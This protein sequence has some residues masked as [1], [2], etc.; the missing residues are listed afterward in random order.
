MIAFVFVG[1]LI[2]PTPPPTF[3]RNPS[4]MFDVA[5]VVVL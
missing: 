3:L 2:I 5:L 1:R 4:G